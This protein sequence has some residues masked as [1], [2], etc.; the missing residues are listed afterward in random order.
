M[1]NELADIL[2]VVA[3]GR[4]EYGLVVFGKKK[5]RIFFA[6]VVEDGEGK[7]FGAALVLGG[8]VVGVAVPEGSGSVVIAGFDECDYIFEGDG[9]VFE[10]FEKLCD[11]FVHWNLI[12]LGKGKNKPKEGKTCMFYN[13]K[14]AYS[15]RCAGF[16]TCLGFAFHLASFCWEM[17]TIDV[18]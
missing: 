18:R 14:A 17:R 11:V 1:I 7:D 2:M 12:G 13:F 8:F 3:I 4:V 6:E 5:E 16:E 15:L 9:I 10:L